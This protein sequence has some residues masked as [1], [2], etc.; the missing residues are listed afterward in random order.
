[1]AGRNDKSAGER[2][3]KADRLSGKLQF[4]D[5]NISLTTP[6][7]IKALRTTHVQ[8]YGAKNH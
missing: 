2:L 5:I 8:V 3:H 4:T 7:A 6:A 1:M